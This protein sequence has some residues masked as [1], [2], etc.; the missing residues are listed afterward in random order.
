M[1]ATVQISIQLMVR[2]GDNICSPSQHKGRDRTTGSGGSSPPGWARG[3]VFRFSFYTLEKELYQQLNTTTLDY[4]V[5]GLVYGVQS[6]HAYRKVIGKIKVYV[7]MELRSAYGVL[8]T[9]I[10]NHSMLV[11]KGWLVNGD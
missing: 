8:W 4:S 5:P 3:L 1:N 10:L 9:P 7:Y 11:T 2:L 6:T